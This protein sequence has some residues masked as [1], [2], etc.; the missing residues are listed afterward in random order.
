MADLEVLLS[1][2]LSS[3]AR[4]AEDL[5]RA[6][7]KLQRAGMSPERIKAVLE[8]DFEQGGPISGPFWRSLESTV[9]DTTGR[10]FTEAELDA[11]A[12]EVLPDLLGD[13]SPEAADMAPM[14][15][16]AALRNTCA[17]CLP[18]HGQVATLGEWREQGLPGTGWSVCTK[19]CKCQLVPAQAGQR[20]NLKKP[21]QRVKSEARKGKY[22][23][24]RGLP[25][26][27]PPEALRRTNEAERDALQR[28][29]DADIRIRRALR[30]LGQANE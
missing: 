1:D 25:M 7:V 9:T 22:Q 27:I 12:E 28:K 23:T 4:G 14:T 13:D 18:R 16:V 2:L 20:M 15:W 11:Y 29:A 30:L 19:H 6:V 8:E 26:E 21:L 5:E 17:D 10:A 24:E 3:V